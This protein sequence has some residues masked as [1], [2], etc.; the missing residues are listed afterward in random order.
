MAARVPRQ[1]QGAE[2]AR[3]HFDALALAEQPVDAHLAVEAG[4]SL[5]VGHDRQSQL[6]R[7]DR[8]A[9]DVIVVEVR[10]QDGDW[11]APARCEPIELELEDGLL[12]FVRR[13]GIDHPQLFVAEEQAV[14]VRRGR[15]RRRQQR[16]GDEPALELELLDDEVLDGQLPGR[17]R[18]RLQRGQ[19]GADVRPRLGQVEAAQRVPRR[20]VQ[21][22]GPRLP[23]RERVGGA[24]PFAVGELAG[25][26]HRFLPLRHLDQVEARVEAHRRHRR[27]HPAAGGQEVAR[28]DREV[29]SGEE[30]AEPRGLA[31]L[32][33]RRLRRG[34]LH[35]RQPLAPR[36]A[37][38]LDQPRADAV[39]LGPGHVGRAPHREDAGF[40]E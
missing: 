36:V 39:A 26:D 31:R 17:A 22:R 5:G 18:G 15:Q 1:V 24:N 10:E 25:P 30:G 29:V 2:A 38:P 8:R 40:L 20:R 34:G 6:P 9:R 12:V 37:G 21:E 4:A 3:P 35:A 11:L 14:R 19:R 13:T 23:A 27:C 7:E 32:V 16:D 33:P 28:V